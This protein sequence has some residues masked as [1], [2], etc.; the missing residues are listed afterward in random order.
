MV[1]RLPAP[2]YYGKVSVSFHRTQNR[3]RAVVDVDGNQ[4]LRPEAGS[5]QM[6]KIMLLAQ[7][8][9]LAH[10]LQLA[11]TAVRDLK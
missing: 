8:G 7:L 3:M 6:L 5:H 4:V 2:I 9:E 11:E 10:D 1:T